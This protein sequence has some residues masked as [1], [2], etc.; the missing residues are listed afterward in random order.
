MKE[1]LQQRAATWVSFT[2]LA[3]GLATACILFFIVKV[4]NN[5]QFLDPLSGDIVENL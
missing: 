2:V 1:Y 4:Q 5:S 3:G